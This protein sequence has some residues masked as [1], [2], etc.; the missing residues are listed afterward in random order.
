MWGCSS[1]AGARKP[2]E[3]GEGSALYLPCQG[4]PP[5]LLPG[6]RNG[7]KG[8]GKEREKAGAWST[9]VVWSGGA[10]S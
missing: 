10:T 7:L 2:C 9:G 3:E 5:A 6:S 8:T 1:K 4:L